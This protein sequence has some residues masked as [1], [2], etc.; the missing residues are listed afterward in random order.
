MVAV[1]FAKNPVR[2]GTLFG[3]YLK[4]GRKLAEKP[5]FLRVAELVDALDLGSSGLKPCGFKSRPAHHF[6]F[7]KLAL[8]DSLLGVLTLTDLT[9][10]PFRVI[11]FV[12]CDVSVMAPSSSLV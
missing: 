4:C 12:R 10:G 8:L 3:G 2:L 7:Q 5:Q 6:C 9:S 11:L 1:A